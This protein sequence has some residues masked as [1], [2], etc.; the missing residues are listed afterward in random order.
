V[1][2][3]FRTA[4]LARDFEDELR[5]RRPEWFSERASFG[6]PESKPEGKLERVGS[7]E[8]LLAVGG[9]DLVLTRDRAGRSGTGF[10]A[11]WLCAWLASEIFVATMLVRHFLG[12]SPIGAR[13]GKGPPV[14]FLSLW[15]AFWTFGGFM[16]AAKLFLLLTRRERWR[17]REGRVI[18]G[19]NW[20]FSSR[21]TLID[22]GHVHA[23]LTQSPGGWQIEL[24]SNG[25]ALN[26]GPF[27][28]ETTA[29]ELLAN[30]RPRRPWWN[31]TTT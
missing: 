25:V 31:W 14:I 29:R 10:M 27:G 8:L 23:R 15:L 5:H 24:V 3:P 19:R 21:R 2:G 11:L 22:D 1:I 20:A 13:P 26:I 9:F 18:A 6:L 17:F 4:Q 28:N 7:W 12:L 16:A 30:L